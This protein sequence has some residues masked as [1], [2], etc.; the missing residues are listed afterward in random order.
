VT[1]EGPRARVRFLFSSSED[2]S[3]FECQLDGKPFLPCSLPFRAKV[4][5]GA[6]RGRRHV[7]RV[8]AFDSVGHEDPTPAHRAFRVLRLD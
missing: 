5:S 7:F 6:G 2:G 4:K 8:A 1:V 3:T